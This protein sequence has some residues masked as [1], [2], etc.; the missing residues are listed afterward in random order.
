MK[1]ADVNIGLLDVPFKEAST[2]KAFRLQ[3]SLGVEGL[4]LALS[5]EYGA[6]SGGERGMPVNI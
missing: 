1:F 5:C 3:L 6:V 2:A 4:L